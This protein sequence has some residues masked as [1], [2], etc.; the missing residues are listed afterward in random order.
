MGRPKKTEEPVQTEELTQEG[1]LDFVS[2]VEEVDERIADDKG[3]RNEL[4]SEFCTRFGISKSEFNAALRQYKEWKKDRS[5][6]NSK[7]TIIDSLLDLMTGEK[8]VKFV[9]EKDIND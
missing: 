9:S 4:I 3:A 6:F 1:L 2:Q 5:K 7:S 8:V